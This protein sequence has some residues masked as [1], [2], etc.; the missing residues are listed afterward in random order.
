MELRLGHIIDV[1][2]DETCRF[3]LADKRRGS[4]DDSLG[5]RDVHDLEEEPRAT[6]GDPGQPKP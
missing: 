6:I 3:T 1:G 4:C 5:T 2:L